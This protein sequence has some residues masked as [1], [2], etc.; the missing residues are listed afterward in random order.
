M[1]YA[2][3]GTQLADGSGAAP[4]IFTSAL[5]EGIRTGDADRDQDGHVALGELYDY[6]YD[7]V[8][9]R[10]PNQTP[11]K[12]EFGLRGD[13]YVARNP[14]RRPPSRLA[15][16]LTDLVRHPVAAA[17][18]AAAHELA[19]LLTDDESRAGEAREA[20]QRLSND[21][22]RQVSAAAAE[23]LAPPEPRP[24]AAPPATA[25]G[26]PIAATAPSSPAAASGPPPKVIAPSPSAV[27]AEISSVPDKSGSD[28]LAAPAMSAN[29]RAEPQPGGGPAE[30]LSSSGPAEPPPAGGPAAPEAGVGRVASPRAS[31]VREVVR[32]VAIMAAIAAVGAGLIWAGNRSDGEQGNTNGGRDYAGLVNMLP[33]SLRESCH[34]EAPGSSSSTAKAQCSVGEFALWS[35]N[36]AMDEELGLSDVTPRSCSSGPPSGARY[37]AELDGRT[38]SVVCELLNSDQPVANQRYCVEWGVYDLLLTGTFY[39]TEGGGEGSYKPTYDLAMTTLGQLPT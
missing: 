23:A 4:S 35:T 15:P 8:R 25:S 29:V 20:L 19:A 3:E 16:E 30:P 2:F 27:P 6:V 28:G 1:E 13:L 33:A 26:S 7:R 9:E 37:A 24:P 36:A 12:W 21:D 17:R 22:S 18:L 10:T 32:V 38:G 34:S 39:S 14:H 5:V 11:S 31:R